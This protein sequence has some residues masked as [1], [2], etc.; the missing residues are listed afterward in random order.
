MLNLITADVTGGVYA[1]ITPFTL[2]LTYYRNT[3]SM[4]QDAKIS[5]CSRGY[6]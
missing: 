4:I 1:Y 2:Y 3:D 5:L 6:G